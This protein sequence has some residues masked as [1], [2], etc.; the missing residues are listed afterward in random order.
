MELTA[1]VVE[2]ELDEV[3]ARVMFAPASPAP[4]AGVPSDRTDQGR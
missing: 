4:A 2:I 3:F 1:L